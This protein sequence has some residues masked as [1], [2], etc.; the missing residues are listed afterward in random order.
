MRTHTNSGSP[1]THPGSAQGFG[2]TL[3]LIWQSA[4]QRFRQEPAE[5]PE[6][7][8]AVKVFI[9]ASMADCK[10]LDASRLRLKVD[11][12]SSTS[13]LTALREEIFSGI[14]QARWQSVA[15]EFVT[16]FDQLTRNTK[17][18]GLGRMNRA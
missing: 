2:S 4:C 7:L 12:A 5:D 3:G 10:G 8:H 14:A 17:A 13:Q 15:I 16:T 9:L 6:Y 1:A 11:S 18:C